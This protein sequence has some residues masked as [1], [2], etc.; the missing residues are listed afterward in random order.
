[1]KIKQIIGTYIPNDIRFGKAYKSFYDELKK[2]NQLDKIKKEKWKLKKLNE[3]LEYSY[4]NIPYYKELFDKNEIKLPLENFNEIKNIPYLTKEDIRNNYDK[5]ISLQNI[6]SKIVNTGG[7]TGTPLKLKKS[8]LNGIKEAVFLDYYMQELGLKRFKVKKAILRG[9]IPKTGISE[10]I[11]RQLILSSYLITDENLKFYIKELEK[12]NPEIFHVYPSSIYSLAKLIEKY[13]LQIKLPNLKVIFASSETFT[14]KQKD[15]VFKIFNC[16]IFDLYGNTETSVQAINLYPDKGYKFNDFYSYVEIVDG[17]IISTSF[18]DLT[19]PLIRYKT[20]DEIEYID[21]D[22]FII[23]GRVQDYIY[24]KNNEK[25][26]VVGIIFGQHFDSFKKMTNFQIIQDKI[27][28]ITFVIE[29]EKLTSEE[30]NDIINTLKKAGN[31]SL[32]VTIKY[33]DKIKRTNRGKYKFLIQ[34]IK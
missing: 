31:N 23:K 21:E 1:M 10:K 3:I 16:E 25:F 13:N 20:G 11:G 27:G 34:N 14:K 2:L 26:P 18:N 24:G 8:K 12:F 9:P 29:G 30:E 19:M 15:L 28:E 5:L 7:S 17:E 4:E 22:N 33:I 32:E 6:D